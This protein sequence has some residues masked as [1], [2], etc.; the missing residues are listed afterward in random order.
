MENYSAILIH[1]EIEGGRCAGEIYFNANGVFFTATQ[2]QYSIAFNY[3]EIKAGGAGNRFIFFTQKG[4]SEISIYTADRS[5][6]RN[7]ELCSYP[8]LLPEIKKSSRR[9]RSLYIT[10]A[11]VAATILLLFSSLFLF[12]DNIIESAAKK[13]PPKW[14]H[15][16]GDKLF[17][18]LSLN[19]VLVKGDSLHK[20][21]MAVAKAWFDEIEKEG[22]DIEVYFVKDATINAFALPGGKVI[23]QTGLVENAKSWEEVLGVLSHEIA[24]VSRRHHI[25]SLLNNVGIYALVSVMFGDISAIIATVGSVGGNLATLANS[26][27]FEYEADETGWNYL[28]QSEINPNGMITFF[29]TLESQTKTKLDSTVSNTLDLSFLSTHPDTQDRINKLKEKKVRLQSNLLIYQI[30]LLLLKNHSLIMSKL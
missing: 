17:S 4:N 13:I 27:A 21:V 7:Q 19:Y 16:I 25:R 23:I 3:L 29:E 26:R 11:I 22:F 5:V 18:A 10:L 24:H 12:K 20:E 8:Q 6:L 1:P 9:A 30:I 28:V 15:K 14:E 2:K